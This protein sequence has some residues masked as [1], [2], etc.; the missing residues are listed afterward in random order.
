MNLK[1]NLKFILFPIIV[2]VLIVAIF[3]YIFAVKG[4]KTPATMQLV[5]EVFESNGL[6]YGDVTE[7]YREKWNVDDMLQS[8]V[9]CEKDD[10]RFDFFVFDS[11]ASAEHIRK[12]Y[13]SYIRENR[14][15]NPNIEVSEG[16]S[17]YM[18]YS[19]K[20]AGIY[21]INMRVENTLVFAYC[22]EENA[23]DLYKIMVGIGYF[24]E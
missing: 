7:D 21:T 3:I 22:N 19:I 1:A 18:L 12:Q 20:A 6:M 5:Q 2:V 24:E 17:N 8:A 13:Q 15:D 9:A 23:A 16:V 10:L 14:Y 4:P 11:D